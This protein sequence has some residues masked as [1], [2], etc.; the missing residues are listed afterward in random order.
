MGDTLAPHH[1][2][3][4]MAA[5]IDGIGKIGKAAFARSGLARLFDRFGRNDAGATAVEFSLVALPFIALMF[6]IIETALAFFAQNYFEDTLA[7]TA[8]LV[9]TGQAQQVSTNVDQFKAL[10]CLKLSPMFNCP[11]GL[12]LDVRTYSSF[13]SITLSIPTIPAGQPNAGNLD[14]SNTQY[15]LG[16]GG[17]IVLVRAYYAWPVFVNRLGNNLATM[18]NGT[19]LLVATAAFRNE[20]FPW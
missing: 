8:R 13:G 15:N 1:V 5:V 2:F 18:P 3:G 16:K 11:G 6:A 10:M 12:T 14:T 9:R 17:D 20:P 7:R 19:R 4:V